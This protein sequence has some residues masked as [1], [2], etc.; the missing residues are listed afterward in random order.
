MKL[1]MFVAL[2]LLAGCFLIAAKIDGNVMCAETHTYKTNGVYDAET[3]TVVTS[4]GNVWG[5]S[6]GNL[7]SGPVTVWVD[8]K[9]T[10]TKTDDTI[11]CR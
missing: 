8:D 1:R 6:N 11:R 10:E 7:V 3:E 2:G 5:Y 9:G 4:D